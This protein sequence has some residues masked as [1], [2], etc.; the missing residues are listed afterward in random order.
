L[1]SVRAPLTEAMVHCICTYDTQLWYFSFVTLLPAGRLRVIKKFSSWSQSKT[2]SKLVTDEI[3]YL[4]ISLH[5]THMPLS[6]TNKA[7]YQHYKSSLL[8]P[9]RR[10]K[11]SLK[12]HINDYDEC[13][14]YWPNNFDFC[15]YENHSKENTTTITCDILNR[16]QGN[17][18]IEMKQIFLSCHDPIFFKMNIH[19]QSWSKKIAS[20]LQDIQSWS[21]PCSPLVARHAAN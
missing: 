3:D 17:F 8:L 20:I 4:F 5:N 13:S 2:S 19:V 1:P 18:V 10:K 21:C 15:E 11:F 9:F 12:K 6:T 7:A 14:T 16:S